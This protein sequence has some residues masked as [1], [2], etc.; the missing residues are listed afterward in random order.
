MW[1]GRCRM[2]EA[3]EQRCACERCGAETVRGPGA[4]RTR[5]WDTPRHACEARSRGPSAQTR[6]HLS[7]TRSFESRT[8]GRAAGHRGRL[9]RLRGRSTRSRGPNARTRN[10]PPRP[11]GRGDRSRDRM[12]QRPASGTH[13]RAAIVRIHPFYA[14]STR[15]TT[16]SHGGRRGR[17][18]SGVKSR[19][20][21]SRRGGISTVQHAGGLRRWMGT[22]AA[23]MRAGAVPHSGQAA[24]M[25]RPVRS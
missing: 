24:V 20:G 22:H 23:Q 7:R 13:T 16:E 15:R 17:G 1:D 14:Y 19:A 3:G 12:R 5:V 2:W 25:A 10:A 4:P 21:D 18:M 9:A 6:G 11:R 8:R